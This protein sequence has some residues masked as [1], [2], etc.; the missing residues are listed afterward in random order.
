[1][2]NFFWPEIQS[3]EDAK[4]ASQRGAGVAFFI[5]IAT[6]IVIFLQTSGKM[7]LFPGIGYSAFLD[8][9]I[10]ILVGI[11]LIRCSRIAAVSGLLLY[12]AEQIYS[13]AQSGRFNFMMIIF[14]L[15]FITS[16]RGTFAYHEIKKTLQENDAQSLPVS[17]RPQEP[18]P[19]PLPAKR[20]MPLLYK[21]GFA[22]LAICLIIAAFSIYQ[23]FQDRRSANQGI[24]I[25]N[26]VPSQPS[27][28]QVSS[29]APAVLK[30]KMTLKL[31]TG[32]TV[33]GELIYEDDVYYTL[34]TLT[35]EE[36]VIK[37][38][39]AK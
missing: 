34:K 26:T 25:E 2:G 19:E 22:I 10:F 11:F 35:G 12:A 38:D 24:V 21:I 33:S 16:V 23:I 4:S 32:Q 5:A 37:E 9:A 28:S 31:K 27:S 29:Q 14:T 7:N 1:M 15:A 17:L 36:I 39:L 18:L 8:V 3:L 13:M 30:Q 20:K 6:T